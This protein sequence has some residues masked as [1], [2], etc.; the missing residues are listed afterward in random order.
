VSVFSVDDEE[1]EEQRDV[2]VVSVRWVTCDVCLCSVLMM[3]RTR[4]SVMCVL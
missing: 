1:E 2:C 4:N 3:M